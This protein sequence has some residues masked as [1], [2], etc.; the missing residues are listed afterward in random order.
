MALYD[1]EFIK[2]LEDSVKLSLLKNEI[3]DDCHEAINFMIGNYNQ[4]YHIEDL[5]PNKK[6]YSLLYDIA[7]ERI[8]V[9]FFKPDSHVRQEERYTGLLLQI[10][11]VLDVLTGDFPTEKSKYLMEKRNDKIDKI[12]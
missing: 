11:E 6:D 12:I 4:I 7:H 8:S 5:I 1:R 3:T 10:K 9:N 2:R